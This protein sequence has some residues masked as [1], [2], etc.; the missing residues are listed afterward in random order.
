MRPH[1][2]DIG[3]DAGSGTVEATLHHT[4]RIGSVVRL[5]LARKDNGTIVEVELSRERFEHLNVATGNVVHFKP[6]RARVFLAEKSCG[7][8]A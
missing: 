8:A 2:I 5:E 7:N 4:T 6:R 3:S 1:D